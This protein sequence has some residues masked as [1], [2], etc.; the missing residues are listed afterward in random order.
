MQTL[1]LRVPRDNQI[2]PE[3]ALNLFSSLTSLPAYSKLKTLISGQ[4]TPTIAFEI[5]VKD[6]TIFFQVTTHQALTSYV[7]SQI[8]AQYPNTTLEIDKKPTILKSPSVSGKFKLTYPSFYPLK[9]FLGF[10]ELDPLASILG[11]LS[12]AKADDQYLFQLLIQPTSSKWIS[13]AR[14]FIDKGIPQPDGHVKARPDQRIIEEKIAQT[15]F[16]FNLN[17]VAPNKT[18]LNEL[19]HTFGAFARGDANNLKFVSKAN[20]NNINKRQFVKAPAQVLNL[21]ELASLWHL[22]TDSIKIPNIAWAEKVIT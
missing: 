12:K 20:L 19:A 7:Q 9:T 3:A 2:G 8:L 21:D 14:A 17:I 22:P 4:K 6:Q 16:A 15:G 5:T 18:K 1:K 13:Q 10:K 11:L